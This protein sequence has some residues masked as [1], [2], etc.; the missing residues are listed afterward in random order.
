MVMTTGTNATITVTART[1][2]V[3]IDATEIDQSV[4][5]EAFREK[6]TP[7]EPWGPWDEAIAEDIHRELKWGN[8]S[9]ENTCL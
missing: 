1:A 8:F 4:F 3:V 7:R 6:P 2:H 5:V 9:K